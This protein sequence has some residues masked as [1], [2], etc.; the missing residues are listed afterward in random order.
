MPD[1]NNTITQ[2]EDLLERFELLV[3]EGNT[4]ILTTVD[5]YN[6]QFEIIIQ[7][8]NNLSIIAEEINN[9]VELNIVE[10]VVK[11]LEIEELVSSEVSGRLPIT[12]K[13]RN[14]DGY[15]TSIV[16]GGVTTYTFARN[17]LNQITGVTVT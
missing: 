6:D 17:S 16:R 14:S 10:E 7:E 8:E 5:E 13:N 11:Y 12:Q 15:I 1:E 3:Q 2:E 9:I 4:Y